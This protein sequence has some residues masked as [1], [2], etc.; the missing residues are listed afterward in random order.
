MTTSISR[1]WIIR[2]HAFIYVSLLLAVPATAQTL[3]TDVTEE[4][5]LDA[6]PGRSARNVVFVD[7][8][9]DGFQDVFITENKFSRYI[10]LFHNAKDGRFED[11]TF[12]VQ[13]EYRF[14]EGWAG[15]IFGDYDNDG[16][17]DLFLSA[18]PYN[19]LLRNDRGLF[20]RIDPGNDL[21]GMY[22]L[23]DNAIWLDY[24]R[25]GHLDLYVGTDYVSET[26]APRSNR[27]LRNNGDG[28][29]TDQTAAAGLDILVHPERGGSG[30]GMAAGDFNG[31]GWPDIYIGV[32]NYPNRLFLSDGADG[33]QDATTG[34]IGDEGDA[35][36]LAVG[37]IDND[38]DL[39]IFQA[40]GGSWELGFRS[41][42][43]LNLGEG[44]FIDVT[45]AVG[46]GVG[47]L[48]TNSDGTAFADVD[49]DGDLDLAIGRTQRE[50]GNEN[51]LLLNDGSGIFVDKT[52]VSGIE[53]YGGY[54]A[55]GDYDEDGFVDL[56]Y[57][58]FTR[59]L[60]ALYRNNGNDNHWLRVELVGVESNRSGIGSRL[61]ATS[62]DLTQMREILG[63]VGRQQDERVAH[64]G[65]GDRIR[66]DRLEIRWPSGQVDILTDIPADRKIRVF[67]GRKGYHIVEPVAWE[68][69]DSLMAGGTFTGMLTVRPSLFEPEAEI[70]GVV[71]DLRELGGAETA[72]L[73]AS[74]DGTW[75]LETTLSVPEAHGYKMVS[76]MIDQSTSMGDYWTQ[77]SRRL[78]VLPA[79]SQEVFVDGL[80]T[81]WRLGPAETGEERKLGF[82]AIR[83]GAA[84][85][86]LIDENGT[87]QV[88]LTHIE[89]DIATWNKW[90]G[91][92]Y[93]NWDW[94]PDGKQL[95]V[96]V[97]LDGPRAIYALDADGTRL[98]QLTHPEEGHYDVHPCW[99]PDGT[100]IAFTSD[101]TGENEIW[102]MDAD[103]GNP[104]QLTDDLAG[105]WS[106]CWSPD[107]T[108]IAFVAL[109]H[110]GDEETR[111]EV[112]V[113]DADGGN[114][115][116]LTDNETRDYSPSW[117]PDGTRIAFRAVNTG[118]FV[119]DADG[120]NLALLSS[121]TKKGYTPSWSPDGTKIAFM[122]SENG[123]FT[124]RADGTRATRVVGHPR[125][126][127]DREKVCI[128][129]WLPGGAPSPVQV[130]NAEASA[131]TYRGRRAR[132]MQAEKL[133]LATYQ[134]TDSVEPAGYAL[135]FA[136]HP[137]EGEMPEDGWL[138]VRVND[139]QLDLLAE[140]IDVAQREWQEV[141]I[142][143]EAF[144]LEEPVEQIEF[145]GTLTG[146][147]YLADLR[148]VTAAEERPP[149]AVIEEQMG[150]P[151]TFALEQN[152]PN[153]FNSA[154]AIRF[155]LPTSA[156]VDLAVFNLAGQKVATL[157]QGGREA[158]RYKV[159][160]D[161]GDDDGRALASGVYLYRLKR[162]NGQQQTRKLLLL[163]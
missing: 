20:I 40:A 67:E 137:G 69:P 21:N 49:N 30:G 78:L 115:V 85:I 50:S 66:V 77:L 142:P 112:Y 146:T 39:D 136:F 55:V 54:I 14:K 4:V 145:S 33:F 48:G 70:T 58:S 28:T 129:I 152:Y 159:R 73:Q 105:P 119:M 134:S 97:Y 103:G 126:R 63:G 31:D 133:W 153:P 130:L 37:D 91:I 88:R 82:V 2:C 116:R 127:D 25:D 151:S 118:I 23:T 161:G 56:L 90:S 144:D 110:E 96:S 98:R 5:G 139:A 7:Y 83:D 43:L 128:P 3:F 32:S 18:W 149:T 62:G 143:L 34:E 11:Q 36:S 106:P 163:R 72:P 53:D 16:D 51:L 101:R 132:E 162:G 125:W 114:P 156:D 19:E 92:H 158:G 86:C 10:G 65:L 71:A 74:G 38:G 75:Q 27:L 35:F 131:V 94:S 84:D 57:A 81:D 47:V 89:G 17:E 122:D 87:N 141:E 26:Y 42:L 155:A 44:R 60:T 8:D 76:V 124:V 140:R 80:G 113:M 102:V 107:G 64:F 111:Y 41:L 148:L 79:E 120:G 9:N 29:F 22:F 121:R 95:V 160:W 109:R 123:I 150:L 68:S 12:R 138:K 24:D 13:T 6:F 61:L 59:E 1:R 157:M 154:T 45:E 52:A 93:P 100:K 99:S 15:S 108:K 46:L 117:S 147:F 104:V 135:N